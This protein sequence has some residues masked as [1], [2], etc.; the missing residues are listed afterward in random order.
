MFSAGKAAGKISAKIILNK[1]I[2]F[3]AYKIPAKD[4][5]F[6]IDS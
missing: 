4:N 1:S 6:G 5:S 2:L 3:I